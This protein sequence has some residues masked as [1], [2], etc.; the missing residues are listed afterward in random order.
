MD[1]EKVKTNLEK[2]GYVVSIFDH[3]QGAK[4]YL[5]NHIVGKTIGFGGSQTLTGMDLRHI[6][7]V[8]NQVFVPDFPPAGETFLD[9]A[10]KA[11]DAEIYL[12]SANAMSE[13]GEI[14]NIDYGGNRLA[15]S[16][17]GHRKVI[18]VVGENKIVG[19]LEDAVHRARNVASPRNALR[20]RRNTPCAVSVIETLLKKFCEQ[21]PDGDQLQWQCFIEG[22]TEEELNTKC[23][24]CK[25]PDRICGSL[26][27]HWQKPIAMDA[28]VLIIRDRKGF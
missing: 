4:N 6:L 7:A 27:I 23:Y 20:Y 28:E 10:D 22:L 1:L 16:L 12:L 25:G 13:N 21:Y 11:A 24:D 15:G 26:L 17:W 3:E 2:K 19:T 8:N 5:R 18:Y 14:I 9:V